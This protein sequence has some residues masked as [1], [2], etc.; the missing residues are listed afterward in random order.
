LK[1]S[2]GQELKKLIKKQNIN[3]SR[4]AEKM[5]ITRATISQILSRDY[6]SLETIEKICDAIGISPIAFFQSIEAG[7]INLES[8]SL[9]SE[10]KQIFEL[11]QD[12]PLRLRATIVD[13]IGHVIEAYRLGMNA[14]KDQ[15]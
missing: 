13:T 11:Y 14:V 4:L 12:L 1:I 10:E 8:M 15:K 5:D 3:Q 2:Y 9:S 7:K 6:P